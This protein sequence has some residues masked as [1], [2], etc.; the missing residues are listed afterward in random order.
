MDQELYY[1]LLKTLATGKVPDNLTEEKK[2]EVEKILT[3]IL[4]TAPPY[5]RKEISK[6]P[7]EEDSTKIQEKLSLDTAKTR[8][9]NK[10][11]ITLSQVTKDKTTPTNAHLNST[12][13][14]TCDKTSTTTFEPVMSAKNE[15]EDKAKHPSNRSRN[16]QPPSTTLASMSWDPY[17]KPG[18]ERNTSLLPLITSPS[19]WRPEPLNQTMLKISS[20]LSMK[21][22]SAAMEFPRS[23]PVIEDPN[24]SM[25]LSR[26]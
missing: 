1:G 18:M 22:L 7:L 13:G 10:H 26:P 5:S 15:K 16:H 6:A 23:S 11:M 8:P 17:L 9:F 12:T 2:N 25:S 4:I 14:P 19:G 21:I 24:S 20:H 3:F